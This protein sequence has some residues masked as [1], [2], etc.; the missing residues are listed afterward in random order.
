[1]AATP[2]VTTAADTHPA[3][4]EGSDS[5]AA[6]PAAG[7]RAVLCAATAGRLQHGPEEGPAARAGC[8]GAVNT[9]VDLHPEGDI[10]GLAGMPHSRHHTHRHQASV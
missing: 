9:H 10:A 8:K 3:A 6:M 5:E 1:L 2:A 7:A 4:A